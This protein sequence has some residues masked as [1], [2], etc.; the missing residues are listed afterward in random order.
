MAAMLPASVYG[1]QVPA[2]GIPVPGANKFPAT[3]S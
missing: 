3:V 2:G 1:L